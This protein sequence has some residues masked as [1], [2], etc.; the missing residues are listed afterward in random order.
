MLNLPKKKVRCKR[1][2]W[3]P[4][5]PQCTAVGCH[6]PH[7]LDGGSGGHFTMDGTSMA[8]DA[9]VDHGK[10]VDLKCHPGNFLSGPTRLR[11]W[12]GEWSGGAS[13]VFGLPKCVGRAAISWFRV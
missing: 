4:E 6:L 9:Q 5:M 3:K 2:E 12:F 8:R 11:C 1:G 10:E 13:T 7:L